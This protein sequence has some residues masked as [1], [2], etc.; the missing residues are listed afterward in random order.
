MNDIHVYCALWSEYTDNDREVMG[1][2]GETSL[3]WG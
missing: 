3:A 1:E 2:L